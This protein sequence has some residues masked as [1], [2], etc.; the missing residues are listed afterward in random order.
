MQD[1]MDS[2]DL[3]EPENSPKI[4]MGD[5]KLVNRI[6]WMG[7][8]TG[9]TLWITANKL[10]TVYSTFSNQCERCLKQ[11]TTVRESLDQN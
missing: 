1:E 8:I 7:Y 6:N 4:L 9:D 11:L 5:S 10:E 2:T 3:G